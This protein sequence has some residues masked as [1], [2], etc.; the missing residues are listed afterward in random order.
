VIVVETDRGPWVKA[1]AAA[2]YRVYPVNPG[3]A[4]RH[5]ETITMPA[6]KRDDFFGAGAL[7]DMGRTGRHQMREL[8]AGSD[9]AG[10]VK[11]AA[12]ARS[13]C[14][15]GPGTCGGCGRRCGSTSPPRRRPAPA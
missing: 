8:A 11:I 1:L 7:A 15:N 10:A 6:S 4:A 12:P 2:G 14:G 9:I 3:Q 13:W 5:K